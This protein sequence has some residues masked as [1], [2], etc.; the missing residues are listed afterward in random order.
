[1]K[2]RILVVLFAVLSVML[3]ATAQNFYCEPTPIPYPGDPIELTPSF[4]AT[5]GN[6]EDFQFVYH[7]EGVTA[8][9]N[10]CLID[11]DKPV[12]LVF[13]FHNYYYQSYGKLLPGLYHVILSLTKKTS[14][15]SQSWGY[16]SFNIFFDRETNEL[17]R[18]TLLV[19]S[20]EYA[21][22]I[23]T[24]AYLMPGTYEFSFLGASPSSP[25]LKDDL[26]GNIYFPAKKD[27]GVETVSSR[28][29]NS[30]KKRTREVVMPHHY[31]SVTMTALE[32]DPIPSVD[33]ILPTNHFPTNQLTDESQ[34]NN[35][36][37]YYPKDLPSSGNNYV[38][39]MSM[40]D[41]EASDAV[42][43][44]VSYDG[45]GRPSQTLAGGVNPKGKYL[46]S[47]NVYDAMSNVVQDWA[48]VVGDTK[49]TVLS[50]SGFKAKSVSDYDG[51]PYGYATMS[52]DILDR[53][54]SVTQ[55]GKAW[56]N[57]NKRTEYTV[58]E[59]NTVRKYVLES[60]KPVLSGYYSKGSL[61]CV[62]TED[63]DGH[64][65]EKYTNGMGNVVLERRGAD[66]CTYYVYNN[67]GQLRFVLSPMYQSIPDL[68]LFAYQY[69]YDEY[70]KVKTK[71]LPGCD[72]V[73]YWY[74]GADRIIKMQDGLLR[75]NDYYRTY[76]YDAYGRLKQQNLL[77]SRGKETCEI[78]NYY[79]SYEY[80]NE[81]C[82]KNLSY[83]MT[84]NGSKA[85]SVIDYFRNNFFHPKGLL[86]ETVQTASNGEELLTI[87]GYDEKARLSMKADFGL[88]GTLIITYYKY[89]YFD[90]VE[91]ETVCELNA[92]D[93][94]YHTD[95]AKVYSEPWNQWYYT[96][97]IDTLV[98][99]KPSYQMIREIITENKYDIPH[100]KLLSSSVITITDLVNNVA[101]TDTIQKPTYDEFGK[102]IANDR[103]GTMGDMSYEY[104]KLHGW[105]THI[106]GPNTPMG[107]LF[108]QNLYRETGGDYARWNG[109]ISAM[110][111]KY[112]SQNLRRY[113]YEYDELNRLITAY[114][115]SY[116][117]KSNY[118]K[119]P[120]YSLIPQDDDQ[121]EDFSTE[122]TYDKNSNIKTVS[123]KGF[124][125]M[126]GN[127]TYGTA[128][129]FVVEYNGNQR[130]K[131]TSSATDVDYDYFESF[132]Y[133]DEV[134]APV[135]YV[136]DGNGNLIEDKEKGLT[137]T[138]DLLGH[139]KSV[140][141]NNKR[142]DYVYAADG[143][144]LKSIHKVD[145]YEYGCAQIVKEYIGNLIVKNG[146]P[147]MY[148]FNGGYYAFDAKG[149]LDGVRFYIQDYQGNNRMTV[150]PESN[151]EYADESIHYYP[152]GSIM[153]NI[154]QNGCQK[155]LYNGKELDRMYGLDLYDYH[156]RQQDPVVPSFNSVDPLAEKTP[157]VSPYSYCA[158]D[159]VNCVDPDGKETYLFATKLPTKPGFVSWVS[160]PATHTFI[161]VRSSNGSITYAAYGPNRTGALSRQRYSQ[162][163][164][165][166][167]DYF[168]EGM[169]NERTKSVFKIQVPEGMS[170]EEF[171]NRVKETINSY[172]N[173][174]G[175]QY[176]LDSEEETEGNCNTSTSTILL[177][178]G[179]S[180][181]EIESIESDIP[182][183]NWGFSSTS[184]PW[185]KEEQQKA[186]ELHLQK[187][188]EEINQQEA[189]Q[190]AL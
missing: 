70:G 103:S 80:E 98:V 22:P 140:T 155:F 125:C 73:E 121:V 109:S 6:E 44:V 175:I 113:D 68:H 147:N 157:E 19:G 75:P 61:S 179:V 4:F 146:K 172:G 47:L 145:Y 122:Y 69:T 168:K 12:K 100:T 114:Y 11:V 46:H 159:P 31:I 165:A 10:I 24:L 174:P 171:D 3:T 77:D 176:S 29:A 39:S 190:K 35:D 60:G 117:V 149:K 184:K 50:E 161:V 59:S 9:E 181:E 173:N 71:K 130:K 20:D 17:R 106:K 92:I 54:T 90:A 34:S 91:K 38:M 183:I 57:H 56:R 84:F 126:D 152:Y 123:R 186:I 66:N 15:N 129:D 139:L 37:T 58:N 166:Y 85:C 99:D 2:I 120:I 48:P 104:D 42:I 163:V 18:R 64:T 189:L 40:L 95:Y 112:G 76:T 170:S 7:S 79:D 89:N 137:Y 86:A 148:Q 87:F 128:D 16:D 55:P 153:T 158:G 132:N 63:E 88:E 53:N 62:K 182:G 141:G 5:P 156:A 144:K 134:D 133:R 185:T 154:S 93:K 78:V 110:E 142:I 136:Y 25:S 23:D 41:K 49:P 101:M 65:I 131:V 164:K 8:N 151:K 81:W 13:N 177:K 97:K 107:T 111:W 150:N 30:T 1:M 138:Y 127:D 96:G 27:K 178:S 26:D 162:D 135:E 105:V 188:K 116:E 119:N 36:H 94:T 115:S 82:K 180:S 160:S 43:S 143:R 102:V 72:P 32:I 21:A 51:D 45:L 14:D 124:V 28:E 187:I 74:D 108:E 67:G 118:S 167:Q 83:C 33:S 52:Y 169:P